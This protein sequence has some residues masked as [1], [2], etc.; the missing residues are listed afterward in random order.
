MDRPPRQTTKLAAGYSLPFLVAF[1]LSVVMLVTDKN[2]QNDF[3]LVN[4]YY[5]HWYGVL[6]TAAI[7]LV[8]AGLLL[9]VRTRLMVKVGV[10]GSTL[11]AISLVAVV[12]TP[13]S[14]GFG[15]PSAYAQYLFGETSNFGNN[16]RYLYDVLLGTYVATAVGGALALALTRPTKAGSGGVDAGTSTVS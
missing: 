11:L 5:I 12:F 9:A 10:L 1:G 2:L 6:V 8:G 15:S 4:P 16:I 7:D 13:G 14:A 3:G